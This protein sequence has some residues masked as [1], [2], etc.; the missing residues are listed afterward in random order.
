M[1]ALLKT[2]LVISII[3]VTPLLKIVYEKLKQH[4]NINVL[5]ILENIVLLLL[6]ALSIMTIVTSNFNSFIYFQF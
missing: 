6:L 3:G 1:N 5:I 4:I 2:S